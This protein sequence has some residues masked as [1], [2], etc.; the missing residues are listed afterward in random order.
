M[1]HPVYKCDDYDFNNGV[2]TIYNAQLVAQIKTLTDWETISQH[3][4]MYDVMICPSMYKDTFG[5]CDAP[6]NTADI[7]IFK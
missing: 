3:T 2:L 5:C 7:I 4:E 6:S 1:F